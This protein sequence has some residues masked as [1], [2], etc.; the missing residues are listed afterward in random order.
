MTRL[1][2]ADLTIGSIWSTAPRVEGDPLEVDPLER[3]LPVRWNGIEASDRPVGT[4]GG[5]VEQ[6]AAGED[7]RQEISSDEPEPDAISRGW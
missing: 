6:V 1:E 7:H 2:D 5:V 3:R 4:H